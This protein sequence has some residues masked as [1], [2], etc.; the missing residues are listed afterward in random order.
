MVRSP[1][2]T[3]RTPGARPAA[4]P[5][6]L[7]AATTPAVSICSCPG[8]L[9]STRCTALAAPGCTSTAASAGRKPSRCART[10][11]RPGRISSC[12]PR[13]SDSAPGVRIRASCGRTSSATDPTRPASR[14]SAAAAPAAAASHQAR[15]ALAGEAA[16]LPGCA[17]A[18]AA[19]T[20]ISSSSSPPSS[21]GA[22]AASAA[23]GARVTWRARGSTPSRSSVRDASP[24]RTCASPMLSTP[25]RRRSRSRGSGRP[26]RRTTAPGAGCTS[27]SPLRRLTDNA[28]PASTPGTTTSDPVP[29]IESV[30]PSTRSP[31]GSRTRTCPHAPGCIDTPSFMTLDGLGAADVHRLSLLP[32]VDGDVA[33]HVAVTV[34]RADHGVVAGLELDVAP[35][36]RAERADAG[37]RH[38]RHA[39][40]YQGQMY[41]LVE[42]GQQ[43][44]Q[45]RNLR[46]QCRTRRRLLLR[47]LQPR[48]RLDANL[49]R[50]QPLGAIDQ[51]LQRI[52]ELQAR[53]G[54]G[55]AVL[56]KDER[57]ILAQRRG[58]ELQRLAPTFLR[59]QTLAARADRG[60]A[61]LAGGR[62]DPPQALQGLDPVGTQAPRSCESRARLLEVAGAQCRETLAGRP[63][64]TVIAQGGARPGE[65]HAGLRILRVECEHLGVVLRRARVLSRGVRIL[66]VR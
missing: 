35:G 32:R 55:L 1:A 27:H 50:R 36:E 53:G 54:P 14:T 4:P 56:R 17:T 22:T 58:V 23:A 60:E 13:C 6:I 46:A 42:F 7:T 24:T 28:A 18:R 64:V 12:R 48:D 25:S 59:L 3:V 66:G 41:G 47:R 49:R 37:Y 2:G 8:S 45:A 34:A 16:A 57:A 52:P 63:G 26:L 9:T 29:P 11:L 10:I 43:R 65:P 20:W 30:S 44:G 38:P 62:I 51:R 5:S 21:G 19:G 31:A 61:A 15:R 40:G 39:V 33:A